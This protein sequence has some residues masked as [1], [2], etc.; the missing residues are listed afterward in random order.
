M[1]RLAENCSDNFKGTVTVMLLLSVTTICSTSLQLQH[2]CMN[3][4]I[5][6]N[7]S[8]EKSVFN[9]FL[10]RISQMQ[11]FKSD[12]SLTILRVFVALGSWIP[13]FSLLCYSG[14]RLNNEY[15]ALNESMYNI[16][17]YLCSVKFQQTL[18]LGITISQK[19][20]NM[21]GFADFRCSYEMFKKVGA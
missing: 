7:R 12:D 9:C 8:I 11:G 13:F 20:V 15:S 14:Q 4:L 19:P 3:R 10:K 1:N 16:S 17:W 21:H 6:T 18:K 5:A 2:V